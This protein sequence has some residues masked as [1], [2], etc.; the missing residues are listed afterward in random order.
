MGQTI[1][2]SQNQSAKGDGDGMVGEPAEGDVVAQLGNTSNAARKSALIIDQTNGG[3]VTQY[4]G[5]DGASLSGKDMIVY[6]V[7][8]STGKAY[9]RVYGDSYVGQRNSEIGNQISFDSSTGQMDLQR[10]DKSTV[11]CQNVHRRHG[12]D[13][14]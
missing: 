8:P 12:F 10:N 9:S 5:I 1:Y 6:G 14:G 4:A 2:R 3:S 13:G 11:A 7:D